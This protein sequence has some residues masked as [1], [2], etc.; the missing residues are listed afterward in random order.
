[1][2]EKFHPFDLDFSLPASGKLLASQN[3]T[4]FR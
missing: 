2:S 4:D 3:F 1:M